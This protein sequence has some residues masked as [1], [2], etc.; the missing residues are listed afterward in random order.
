MYRQYIW[1]SYTV[2]MDYIRYNLWTTFCV[3]QDAPITYTSIYVFY[4][5]IKLACTTLHCFAS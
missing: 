1:N 2:A 4:T 5:V 3:H